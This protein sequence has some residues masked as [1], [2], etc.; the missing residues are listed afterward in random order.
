ML[1]LRDQE[2]K[3]WLGAQFRK[4]M[5]YLIYPLLKVAS[6]LLEDIN[7]LNYLSP[8]ITLPKNTMKTRRENMSGCG[9]IIN[10]S[11]RTFGKTITLTLA[12]SPEESKGQK[13][14]E[15]VSE[16][17]CLS[18]G[19]RESVAK[20]STPNQGENKDGF[21]PQSGVGQELDRTSLHGTLWA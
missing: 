19:S 18:D 3:E 9:I 10:H 20:W 17:P 12:E 21:W 5:K 7:S 15:H 11:T 16:T 1:L 14:L 13:S 4:S 6:I 8:D 2:E